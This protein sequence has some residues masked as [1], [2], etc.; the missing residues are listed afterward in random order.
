MF[1]FFVIYLKEFSTIFLKIYFDIIIFLYIYSIWTLN[2]GQYPCKWLWDYGGD[3]FL[4]PKAHKNFTAVGPRPIT[5]GSETRE[6]APLRTTAVAEEG[7]ARPGIL[8]TFSGPTR[9]C[10]A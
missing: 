8:Q 1:F 5:T 4:K 9:P 6:K 10:V 2:H 7:K 3:K